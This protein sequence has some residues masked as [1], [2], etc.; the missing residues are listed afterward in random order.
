MKK[1]FVPKLIR[2]SSLNV[3]AVE[4]VKIYVERKQRRNS[5]RVDNLEEPLRGL[6]R[7][8]WS[9]GP[10]DYTAPVGLR[11]SG[12]R[13]ADESSAATPLTAAKSGGGHGSARIDDE[14]DGL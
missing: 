6:F 5:S 14:A 1:C 3:V 12:G 9:P 4:S 11:C 2:R 8:S 10:F 7:S 13:E